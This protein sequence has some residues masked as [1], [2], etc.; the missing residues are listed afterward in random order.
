MPW[1]ETRDPYAIW[2]SE[3]MLQ[4]TRVETVIPYYQRFLS[5][6]ATVDEL[7]RADE[8]EVL[9]HWSGLGYYR[10]ARL[11]HAGAK[12]VVREHAGAVPR[13]PEKL[14]A[15]PGVGDYTA[16]AIASIA[17]G[18]PEPILDGN[19][20]RVLTRLF[21]IEGDPRARPQRE[22][23]WSLA[24]AFATH[25]D[26]G[27]V[28]QSLM[29]LGATLCAPTN[30]QCL[31]CPARGECAANALGEPTRFPEKPPKKSPRTEQWTAY[32]VR[33]A[34]GRVLLGPPPADLDRWGGMLLPPLS[35][36][37][38]PSAIVPGEILATV[39]HVLTHARME[40]T[41]TRA[42]ASD[43]AKLDGRFVDEASLDSLAI[44]KVTRVILDAAQS[45]MP[46]PEITTAASAR[47]KASIRSRKG[48]AKKGSSKDTLT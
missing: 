47:T 27:N 17:F 41:V 10:R 13:E 18:L 21:A 22:R 34:Q 6:F 42:T 39:T 12:H 24:R 40:I 37:A 35:L 30:P 2:V 44:P 8:P 3:V 19:V 26:A 32:I 16:G 25:P 43:P 48:R 33:D 9:A 36:D 29:E 15:L 38:P 28:N 11:L 5:R 45:S 31:L 20:E 46:S 4:Q 1:R 7:A 23:L 14:R